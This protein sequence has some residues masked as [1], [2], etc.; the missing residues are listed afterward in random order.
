MPNTDVEE[1]N[2]QP[3]APDV[4]VLPSKDAA[5]VRDAEEA[6][7]YGTEEPDPEDAPDPSRDMEAMQIQRN[8]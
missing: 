1:A 4:E 2:T 5:G 6:G 7:P 8:A 3:Q